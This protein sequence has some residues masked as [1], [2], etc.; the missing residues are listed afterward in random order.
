[1]AETSATSTSVA[2]VSGAKFTFTVSAIIEGLYFGLGLLLYPAVLF[3]LVS[4]IEA[5]ATELYFLR[6]IAIMAIALGIGCMYARNGNYREVKLMSLL[7]L[8]SKGGTTIILIIMLMA[9]ATTQPLGWI[10][11]ILTAILALLNARQYQLA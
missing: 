5:T 9:V 6:L 7:M 11:P 3:N 2:E 8:I 10:N 1:M 4:S